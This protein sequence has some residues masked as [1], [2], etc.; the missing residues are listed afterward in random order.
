MPFTVTEQLDN[1]YTTT[2]QNMRQMTVDNIFT[3]SAFWFWMTDGGRFETQEGGRTIQHPLRFAKSDNVVWIVKGK[4]VPM[5]DKEFLTNAIFN[6]RYLS[7]TIIR[8]GVDEQKNRGRHQNIS[9]VSSKLDNSQDSLID[10]LETATFAAQT[11]DAMNG[12]QDLVAD[13]PTT[14]TVGGID[15]SANTWWR[16]KTTNLTGQ[17]FAVHG[18]PAMRTMINNTGNNLASEQIDVIVSG[19][20]PHEYYED[21]TVEQKQIVNQRL[22]DAGFDNIQ[23]KGRPLI[24]SSQCSNARMYFLNTNKLT[25]VY[26]PVMWFDMTPWKDIPAQPNDRVAQVVSALNLVTS[27]RASQGVIHTIDTE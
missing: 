21:A 16:N 14:G 11:G 4:A 2:W 9:L 12:L 6:W 8:F 17:S 15:A 3:S 1:L 5:G 22:G 24:W 7:D 25:V 20:T 26:D 13:D 19:Q 23:Y 10:T 18:I 27:R